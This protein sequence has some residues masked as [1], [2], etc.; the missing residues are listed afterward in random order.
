MKILK[1]L[2]NR[3]KNFINILFPYRKEFFTIFIIVNVLFELIN[4][5]DLDE[6]ISIINKLLT[7]FNLL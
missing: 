4:F 3:T 7:L 1:D 6:K 5:N 2:I